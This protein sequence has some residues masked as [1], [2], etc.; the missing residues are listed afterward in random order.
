MFNDSYLEHL[1]KQDQLIE[2]AYDVCMRI[3]QK[4]DIIVVTN[5]ISKVQKSRIK[6]SL[7]AQYIKHV[8]VSEDANANKPDNRFFEYAFYICGISDTEKVLMV[9]DSLSADIKGGIDAKVDTCW[10]NPA[11][12]VNTSGIIPVHEIK[13]LM[14]L[15]KLI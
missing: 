2:D 8:I 15:D 3:S 6:R 13:K 12:T 7:I 5:G 9:G 10:F 4:A 11:G 1:S 14:E